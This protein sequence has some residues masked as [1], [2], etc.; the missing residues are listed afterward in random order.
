MNYFALYTIYYHIDNI[1][2]YKKAIQNCIKLFKIHLMKGQ[3][4][5]QASILTF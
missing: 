3:V 5:G 2:I 4:K 1:E